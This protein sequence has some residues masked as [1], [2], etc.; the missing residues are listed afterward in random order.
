M[1]LI[2][3]EKKDVGWLNGFK[4][5]GF[6]TTFSLYMPQKCNLKFQCFCIKL[7]STSVQKLIKSCL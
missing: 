7:N 6:R 1:G 3:Y 2:C 4:M 5:E